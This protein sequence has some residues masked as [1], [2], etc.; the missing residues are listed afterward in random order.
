MSSEQQT[1]ARE[2]IAIQLK[3]QDGKYHEIDAD[4]VKLLEFHVEGVFSDHKYENYSKLYRSE[5]QR[6]SREMKVV[7]NK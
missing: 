3:T 1:Q 4:F 6:R 5:K 2:M 7:V